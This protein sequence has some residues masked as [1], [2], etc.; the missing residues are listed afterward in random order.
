[1]KLSR[2]LFLLQ[3]AV[4]AP[5]AYYLG[6][7][8]RPLPKPAILPLPSKVGEISPVLALGNGRWIRSFQ[9][10]DGTLYLRG[11]LKSLDGGRSVQP[12]ET[13]DVEAI[14]ANPERAILARPEMFYALDG[15]SVERVSPGIYQVT[16]WRSTDNLRTLTT[17]TVSLQVPE[18][19]TR[20]R[21]EG[22]W[23]GLYVYRTILEMPDESW[24]MTM[25]GNFNVDNIIPPDRSSQHEVKFMMRSFVLTSTDQG[26]NWRYLATVATPQ[27]GD[28]IGEGFVEPAIT[29]LVD[30]RLLCIL[31]TGHH[32]PL[33]ASWSSDGGRSWTAPAYTGLDR[34]CDPC[35]I[36]L[37]DGRVALSWGRRY[38]EGWSQLDE[39]GDMERFKSSY[40]GMGLVNLAI[41]NDGGL[42]WTNNSIA[43]G[44]G[45]CY[46]TIIE[47]EAGVLF[48]QVDQWIWRVNLRKASI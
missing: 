18:G 34:G 2:R 33:F 12:Q 6:R 9:A 19:P 4:L 8:H 40:P 41:S 32:Y 17:E 47:V 46:S 20:P 16:A 21:Q 22:E 13:V 38:P 14:T 31:R 39:K 42:T 44:M 5:S 43:R 28:P 48:F 10:A 35:L 7:Q 23:Y 45:S 37:A 36:T 15:R 30:G 25:Y 26:R 29:R 27:P 3:A 24:L 11:N 1:M